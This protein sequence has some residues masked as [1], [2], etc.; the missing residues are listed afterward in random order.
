MS[1]VANGQKLGV[2]HLVDTLEVG[3]A[4]RVAVTLVNHLDQNR[5]V[6]HLCYHSPRRSAGFRRW[7]AA[8]AG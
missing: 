3:G 7:T 5:Y 1:D 6:P 4:E 8:S 2:M